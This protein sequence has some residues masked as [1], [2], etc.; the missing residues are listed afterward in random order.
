MTD[1]KIFVKGNPRGPV[2]VTRVRR[3]ARQILTAVEEIRDG[4]EPQY[5]K[6]DD[7]EILAHDYLA[8]TD[9]GGSA[10][11]EA[12]PSLAKPPR[13]IRSVSGDTL[14]ITDP[15]PETIG[16]AALTIF[17][18]ANFRGEVDICWWPLDK[19][20]LD[21]HTT[22]ERAYRREI[23]ADRQRTTCSTTALLQGV[24]HDVRDPPGGFDVRGPRPG[25]LFD[26]RV[27]ALVI[28]AFYCGRI[29]AAAQLE[30]SYEWKPLKP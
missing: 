22:N 30:A 24:F 5:P 2:S 27:V 7:L 4:T 12:I 23:E 17:V 13:H 9:D 19:D 11:K 10:L 1:R 18:P 20:A 15:Y 21:K 3:H 28:H 8:L 6:P 16:L 26:A 14:L 29:E 25:A